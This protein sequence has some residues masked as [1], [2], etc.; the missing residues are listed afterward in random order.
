MVQVASSYVCWFPCCEKVTV[1]GSGNE[2]SWV[3]LE[4]RGRINSSKL[5]SGVPGENQVYVA[6]IALVRTILV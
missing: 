2:D 4:S 6:M 3:A 1:F 5:V